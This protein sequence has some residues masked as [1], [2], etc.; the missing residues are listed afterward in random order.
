M[1]NEVSTDKI[2]RHI[3]SKGKEYDAEIG[4]WLNGSEENKKTYLDVRSLWQLT[5]TFPPRFSP[6]RQK[7]WQKVRRQIH[8]PKKNDPI[9]QKQTR[10]G[11]PF[12]RREKRPLKMNHFLFRPIVQIAAVILVVLLSVWFGTELGQWKDPLYTEVISPAGQKSRVVLPDRSVVLLNGDSRIRYK[13]N[14]NEHD[15][16]VELEGEGYFDVHKDRHKQFVVEA[17]QLNVKV[18]GTTFNVK[19]YE[20]QRTIEVGLKSGEI[21]IEQ[22]GREISRLQPGEV[23][24]FNKDENKLMVGEMNVDLVSA[25]TRDELIFEEKLME[26]IMENMERWYGVNIAI[27]PELTD[28][29]R[30]TFKV[31]AESLREMLELINL[32]KPITYKIEGKQVTITKP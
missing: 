30:F 32:L 29:D 9:D 10:T 2:I 22:N 7:A 13:N 8:I 26:E 4:E 6:D 25:W 11:L 12:S 3:A 21:G 24:T 19:A 27:A 18:F 17:G 23:A 1:Q 20:H 14:F 28:S 15:R 31:K 5:G 16:I